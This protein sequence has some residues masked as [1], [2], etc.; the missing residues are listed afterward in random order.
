MEN[1][2]QLMDP[3]KQELLEA[4]F[5]GSRGFS[6]LSAHSSFNTTPH[7]AS[8]HQL[9]NP[10]SMANQDSNLSSTSVGSQPS[11]GEL[12]VLRTPPQERKRKRKENNQEPTPKRNLQANNSNSSQ[13]DRESSRDAVR[14]PAQGQDAAKKISEY[15]MK[16][17]AQHSPGRCVFL[18]PFLPV[19]YHHPLG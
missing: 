8:P 7:V 2:N 13:P 1:L 5:L 19:S 14:P 3:R 11:D 4:R 6:G 16:G 9:S 17:Q 10:P 12:Q 18:N 15:F